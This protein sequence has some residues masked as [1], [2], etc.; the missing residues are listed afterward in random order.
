MIE[1][2][3]TH[4]FVNRIIHIYDNSGANFIR[5]SSSTKIATNDAHYITLY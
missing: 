5:N 4:I 3:L 1:F 2:N